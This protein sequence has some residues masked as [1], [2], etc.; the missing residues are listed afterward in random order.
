MSRVPRFEYHEEHNE[1]KLGFLIIGSLRTLDGVS[2]QEY[3]S[4][5]EVLLVLMPNQD[6]LSWLVIM[7]LKSEFEQRI[8]RSAKAEG[9]FK[10]EIYAV[11]CATVVVIFIMT[12]SYRAGGTWALWPRPV[13]PL[14]ILVTKVILRAVTATN[15]LKG[16]DND[17]PIDIPGE[18]K[19][20]VSMPFSVP[21][22]RSIGVMLSL[23]DPRP[24]KSPK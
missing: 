19:C 11:A 13:D 8:Q 20:L 17:F 22:R 6:W 1:L 23:Q 21:C 5:K 3:H 10:Y 24:F 15:S 4:S 2:V 18:Q 16:N 12:Y 7:F 9:G 14:L